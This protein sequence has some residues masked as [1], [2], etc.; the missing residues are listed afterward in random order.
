LEAFC[1]RAPAA[2]PDRVR[3]RLSLEDAFGKNHSNS[4]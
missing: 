2:T 4:R 1:S 3:D